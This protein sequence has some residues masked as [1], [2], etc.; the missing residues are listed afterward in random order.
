MWSEPKNWKP[1]S[2]FDKNDYNRIKNNILHLI[3]LLNEVIDIE[4]YSANLIEMGEDKDYVHNIEAK[5]CNAFET[6]TKFISELVPGGDY[7]KNR[8][9]EPNGRFMFYF[10]LNRLEKKISELYDSLM[11]QRDGRRHLA[12]GLGKK[13]GF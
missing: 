2:N 7:V 4:E 11:N 5:D 6:N 3:D 1:D 12:F 8:T 13:E 9:Y 10:E